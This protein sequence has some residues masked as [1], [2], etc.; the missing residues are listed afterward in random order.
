MYIRLSLYTIFITATVSS[1]TLYPY[2]FSSI[3]TYAY[4]Q[5]TD[6]SLLSSIS[7]SVSKESI[8]ISISYTYIC[9]IYNRSPLSI[10]L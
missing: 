3:Q 2:T 10:D 9:S 1:L 7:L 6:S 4:I 5:V 8:I